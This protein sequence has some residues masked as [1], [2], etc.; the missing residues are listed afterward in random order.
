MDII[1]ATL[2][3]FRFTNANA[4]ISGYDQ[5]QPELKSLRNYQTWTGTSLR[6]ALRSRDFCWSG[7]SPVF[8]FHRYRKYQDNAFTNKTH[9]HILE[10]PNSP[11]LHLRAGKRLCEVQ[12]SS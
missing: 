4:A 1:Q 8:F 6:S 11:L 12:H 7:A 3:L 2:L 10:L 5:A 9:C